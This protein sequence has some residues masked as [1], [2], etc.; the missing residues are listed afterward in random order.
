[1]FPDLVETL[2]LNSLFS[3]FSFLGSGRG[4]TKVRADVQMIG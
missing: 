2:A 3:A 4:T 1:V